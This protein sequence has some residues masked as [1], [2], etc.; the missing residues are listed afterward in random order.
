MR[1]PYSTTPGAGTSAI[2]VAVP[3]APRF[4]SSSFAKALG[5]GPGT[6][7]A[8]NF[9]KIISNIL[10]ESS[11]GERGAIAMRPVANSHSVGCARELMHTALCCQ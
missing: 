9:T 8:E 3:T 7:A 2:L 11:A 10:A 4:L 6:M 1:G 5:K